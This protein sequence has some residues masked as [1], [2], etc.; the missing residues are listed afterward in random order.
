[1]TSDNRRKWK[2]VEMS[3]IKDGFTTDEPNLFICVSLVGDEVCKC[4]MTSNWQQ[5]IQSFFILVWKI[6]W[7]SVD[8]L[9]EIEIWFCINSTFNRLPAVNF[10]IQ[11]YNLSIIQF[12]ILT[13]NNWLTNFFRSTFWS[14]V[15]IFH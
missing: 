6:C 9:C 14:G 13:M 15:Y 5:E 1:M 7:F 10:V 2:R 8:V 4:S 3:R 12:N 11:L